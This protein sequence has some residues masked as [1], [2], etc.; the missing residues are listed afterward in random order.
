MGGRIDYTALVSEF[1]KQDI[2][3]IK[4][5]IHRGLDFIAVDASLENILNPLSE[6]YDESFMTMLSEAAY[7]HNIPLLPLKTKEFHPLKDRFRIK[8]YQDKA[9]EIETYIITEIILGLEEKG[10]GE[11][12]PAQIRCAEMICQADILWQRLGADTNFLS[13]TRPNGA[14]VFHTH[15]KKRL[16][17]EKAEINQTIINPYQATTNKKP[18]EVYEFTYHKKD[19]NYRPNRIGNTR[20]D[21]IG[22]GMMSSLV[23][24]CHLELNDIIK[25]D[26]RLTRECSNNPNSNYEDYLL[27][28]PNKKKVSTKPLF[29]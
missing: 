20:L 3:A 25:E 2:F 13:I 14:E 9:D 7:S 11:Y 1:S 26:L 16:E 10:L 22:I 28:H 4:N 8:E 19:T 6:A 29:F 5:R 24:V 18:Q 12:I 21:A 17:L 23:T 27:A 15:L